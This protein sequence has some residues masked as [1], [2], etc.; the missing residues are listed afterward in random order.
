MP[1]SGLRHDNNT[2]PDCIIILRTIYLG[3]IARRIARGSRGTGIR[4][5]GLERTIDAAVL[6]GVCISAEIQDQA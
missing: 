6:P 5:C 3:I 1:S 4:E 2:N